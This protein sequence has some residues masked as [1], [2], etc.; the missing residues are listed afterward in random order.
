MAPA[1]T[2]LL[3]VSKV[4]AE[5]ALEKLATI[6]SDGNPDLEVNIKSIHAQAYLSLYYAEKIRAATAKAADRN[7]DA[8]TALGKAEGHWKNYTRIMDGMFIG[9]DMLRTR[10]FEDWHV[11]DAAVSREYAALGGDAN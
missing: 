2:K 10:D 3:T 9:A 11:H 5:S 4:A 6:S 8:R 1:R 7:E